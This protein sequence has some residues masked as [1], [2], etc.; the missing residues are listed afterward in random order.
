MSN[1]PDEE[2][3]ALSTLLAKIREGF[4]PE[5]LSAVSNDDL[6]HAILAAGFHRSEE[7]DV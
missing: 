5:G 3:D 2:L 1:P 4:Y 6:A 7:A